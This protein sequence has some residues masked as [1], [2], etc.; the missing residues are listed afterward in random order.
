MALYMGLVCKWPP[1]VGG[2]Q[3]WVTFWPKSWGIHRKTRILVGDSNIELNLDDMLPLA[4][5]RG[6]P[7]GGLGPLF[8]LKFGFSYQNRLNGVRKGQFWA[9]K[10]ENRVQTVLVCK[11]P[12]NLGAVS[13]QT[14]IKIG[15]WHFIWVWYVN[16]LQI[17]EA[18][19]GQNHAK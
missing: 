17:W 4:T 16:G 11:P 15:K 6:P 1:N 19:G 3:F 7:R 18:N 13:Y 10:R 12:P 5:P 9:K 8:S 2:S 14:P